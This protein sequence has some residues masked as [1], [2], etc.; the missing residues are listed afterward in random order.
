[1]SPAAGGRCESRKMIHSITTLAWKPFLLQ[2]SHVH[3]PGIIS[4]DGNNRTA[5]LYLLCTLSYYFLW[6]MKFNYITVVM[7]I[8]I[9]HYTNAAMGMCAEEQVWSVNI[10]PFFLSRMFM[11]NISVLYCFCLPIPEQK[12]YIFISKYIFK[13]RYKYAC[14]YIEIGGRRNTYS[15]T[16]WIHVCVQPVTFLCRV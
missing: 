2:S 11:L 12:V 9:I 7:H 13:Y 16:M 15:H 4:L 8:F 10:F 6:F 3:L 1:M 14:V 5:C